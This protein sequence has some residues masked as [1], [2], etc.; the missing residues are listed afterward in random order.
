MAYSYLEIRPG[1][2]PDEADNLF[3]Y[4][5]WSR[6]HESARA[7]TARDQQGDIDAYRKLA[8]TG[9]DF[10]RV[11][12]K[13]GRIKPFQGDVIHRQLLE[14]ILC[15]ENERLTAEELPECLDKYCVCGRIHDASAA[16]KQMR[17]LRKELEAS[18]AVQKVEMQTVNAPLPG[19]NKPK[20]STK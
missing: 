18:V 19:H 4:I 1:E 11:T 12:F 15:F 14:L 16:I 6:H 10:R 8:R 17:R 13:K 20:K 5:H 3:A 2:T 7:T 9:E